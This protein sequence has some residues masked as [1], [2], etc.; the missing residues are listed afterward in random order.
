MRNVK[1]KVRATFN[2]I[3]IFPDVLEEVIAYHEEYK[4]CNTNLIIDYFIRSLHWPN[5]Y[6][7]KRCEVI[8]EWKTQI[9]CFES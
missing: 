4:D 1:E 8:N 5:Y 6:Y 7:D 2:R 9:S 3:V